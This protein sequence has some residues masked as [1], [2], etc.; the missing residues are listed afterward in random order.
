MKVAELLKEK[1]N[2]YSIGPVS[3]S[4]I[5]DAEN[6]LGVKFS[7][8]FSEIIKEFGAYSCLGHELTGIC[9]SK[10]LNVVDVTLSERENNPNA[11]NLY[12]IELTNVDSI[13]IWQSTD[14]KIYRTKETSKPVLIKE[15]LIEYLNE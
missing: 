1:K 10:R 13:V 11:S 3:E 12:V 7:D 14:G 6:K 8:D 5:K 9:K 2:V 4:D 15:S